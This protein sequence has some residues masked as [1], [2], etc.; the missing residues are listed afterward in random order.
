M[1]LCQVKWF[2]SRF[3]PSASASREQTREH[4]VHLVI[5]LDFGFKGV[6]AYC[7]ATPRQTEK[8]EDN[9]SFFWTH[10]RSIRCSSHISPKTK[11]VIY[12]LISV[13]NFSQKDQP[14]SR[15]S[16]DHFD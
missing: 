5:D 7:G 1:P 16:N 8:T 14:T 15:K 12:H 6:H 10:I 11:G 4:N 3:G 2:S 9:V 13:E